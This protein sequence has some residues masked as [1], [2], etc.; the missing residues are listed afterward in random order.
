MAEADKKPA[1]IPP[2]KP[3]GGETKAVN[4]LAD[5]SGAVAGKPVV[6]ASERQRTPVESYSNAAAEAETAVAKQATGKPTQQPVDRPANNAGVDQ[7]P[8]KNVV[9]AKKP[10][11]P[12][13][14]PKEYQSPEP[15]PIGYWELPDQVRMSVPEIKFSV[16]VYAELAEDRFVLINGQRLGEG[17][18]YQD[19][20]LIKEIR[21]D[22]V[23]FTYRLYQF[24]VER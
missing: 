21:R 2:V 5:D 7:P 16:L 14:P 15:E 1:A 23:V 12:K 10:E 17:D 19:G 24:L 11:N 20:L 8:A 4:Q 13:K 22:G 9:T 6:T 3:A 18:S